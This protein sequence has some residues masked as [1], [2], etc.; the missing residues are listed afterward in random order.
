[1]AQHGFALRVLDLAQVDLDLVADADFQLAILTV[2][3]LDGDQPLRFQA[4]MHHHHVV[5][6]GLDAAVED[7]A[8]AHSLFDAALL[9]Q[10]SKTLTH[11]LYALYPL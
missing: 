9:E 6:D 5:M 4:G 8:G 10:L 1:V 2:E 7:G 11:T 3:L